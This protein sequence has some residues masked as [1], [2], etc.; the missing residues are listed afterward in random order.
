M[1]AAARRSRSKKETNRAAQTSTLLEQ[2]AE[3]VGETRVEVLEGKVVALV[4]QVRTRS[5]EAVVV[6]VVV[7]VL[8]L[9]SEVRVL[10]LHRSPEAVGVVL[11]LVLRGEEA[12]RDSEALGVIGRD[13]RGVDHRHTH[14]RRVLAS[15]L[16]GDLTAPAEAVQ[17]QLLRAVA[18]ELIDNRVHILHALADVAD[19]LEPLA[20]LLA[21]RLV[22]RGEAVDGPGVVAEEVRHDDLSLHR[23]TKQVRT[24]LGGVP[25]AEDVED[26]DQ[27][28][29]R[30]LVAGHVRVHA[31]DLLGRALRGAEVV[32]AS[33]HK[34]RTY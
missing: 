22:T 4:L 12:D 16:A 15:E 11:R 30:V 7:L 19:R 29:R 26:A 3:E 17:T 10:L 33:G 14:E 34:R 5:G 23:V 6:L 2:R 1:D 27:H 24:L 21:L 18:L 25:E 31:S 13:E 9:G 20:E 8:A 32:L 28:V